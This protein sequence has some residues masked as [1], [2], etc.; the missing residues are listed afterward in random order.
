[1]LA[2]RTG[3]WEGCENLTGLDLLM[4]TMTGK[5]GGGGGGDHRR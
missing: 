2:L 5:D 3:H 1:M 4:M